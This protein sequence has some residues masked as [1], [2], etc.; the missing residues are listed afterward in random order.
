VRRIAMIFVSRAIPINEPG[1]ARPRR[2]VG[3]VARH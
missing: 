1:A 3:G 2:R